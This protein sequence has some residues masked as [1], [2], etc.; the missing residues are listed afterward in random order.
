MATVTSF[1][2]VFHTLVFVVPGF[3]VDSVLGALVPQRAQPAERSVL[4]LLTFSAI[5]YALWSWLIYLLV[6][7]PVFSRNPW[8]QA[9]GWVVVMGLGPAG[10]GLLLGTLQQRGF[11]K[12]VLAW[13]GVSAIHPIPRAWDWAFA[14]GRAGWALVTLKNGQ[15]IAGLFGPG[16]FASSDP[17]HPDLYL[18]ALYRIREDGPWEQVPFTDGV[19][20]APSEILAIEFLQFRLQ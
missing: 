9:L 13:F 6:A 7:S 14:T 2:V 19:W 20:I 5:N 18:E 15:R 1:E 10:L 3:I 11:V 12:T 16:S 17:A 4:R 8:T